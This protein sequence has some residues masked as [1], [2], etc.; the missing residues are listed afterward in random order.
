[1]R[2]CLLSGLA[3]LLLIGWLNLCGLGLLCLWRF[4][5]WL[6]SPRLFLAACPRLSLAVCSF[7]GLLLSPPS[8]VPVR[9]ARLARDCFL[10]LSAGLGCGL[11][12]LGLLVSFVCD[13]ELAGR[14][15]CV[16]NWC[17]LTWLMRRCLSPS[18]A[19]L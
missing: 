10:L 4:L 2:E 12:S 16:L 14:L 6:L 5:C 13:R 19:K 3:C 1:V 17:G 18:T 9:L 8:H 11:C 15:R 7:D